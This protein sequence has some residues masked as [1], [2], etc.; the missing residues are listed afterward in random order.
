MLL[1][2]NAQASL[3][4]FQKAWARLGVASTVG[5]SKGSSYV[6]LIGGLGLG[7]RV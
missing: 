7:V 1:F 4:L 5:S 2:E 3:S 6:L